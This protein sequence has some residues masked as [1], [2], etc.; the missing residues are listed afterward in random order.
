MP[1]LIALFYGCY[2]A[3][4]GVYVIFVPKILAME[5]M[6]GLEIGFILSSAPLVRFVVPFL[7]VRGFHLTQNTFYL[8]LFL[9]VLGGIG[10]YPALHHFWGLMGVNIVFGIGIALILPYVEVIALECIG[11]EKYG[12]IRLF[13]SI[14]FIAVALLLGKW[15]TEGKIGIY[16][17]I[18]MAL[19]TA[20]FGMLIGRKHPKTHFSHTNDNP[21]AFTPLHHPYLWIGFLLMQ[22]SFA[23]FYNFFTLYTADH[24]LPLD[25]IVWLWSFGVIAEIIMFYFQGA[26][27]RRNLYTILWVTSLLTTLRWLLVAFFPDSIPLL[28]LAQSLHAF[29]FALFYTASISVLFALYP[30][31]HLAQ[32]FFFGISYGL[33]GFVGALGA[34]FMYHAFPQYLFGGASVVALGATLAFY[35]HTKVTKPL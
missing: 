22:V 24:G 15:L 28:L 13:G 14:G 12:K 35:A 6:N 5:G 8:S 20:F 11:R 7:F 3:L 31:R 23:A 27:L 21:L 9:M 16:Y 1:S 33:G 10:F 26:L 29:G 34:G 2:F 4:I 25:T 30:A 19:T 32:Q 18:V 17:L